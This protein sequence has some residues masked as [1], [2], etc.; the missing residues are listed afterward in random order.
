MT[1]PSHPINK[2]G[3]SDRPREKMQEKGP[4]Q[5]SDAEIIAIL[6]ATGS[7]NKSAIDLARS[8][9][10]SSNNDISELSRMPTSEMCKTKGIGPAKATTL[11]A[12]FELGRRKRELPP[13]NKQ[14]IES[15][16]DVFE[17]FL[18]ILGDLA[19]EEFWIMNLNRSNQV[20]SLRKIS[21]GGWHSTIVDPKKVFSRA[22]EERASALIVAHNH[23]SGNVIPSLEDKRITKKLRRCGQ[24]LELPVLDH[25]II[26]SHGY[27]SFAD[28]GIFET[29]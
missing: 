10:K 9:L 20:I 11:Q 7:G 22:L 27:F 24:D 29:E 19:H 4:A 21:E 13:R 17:Y 25:L 5:L 3:I 8:L 2:W 6:I 16:K 18:S 28:E 14:K 23:P 1:T 15:S 26:A 12:A